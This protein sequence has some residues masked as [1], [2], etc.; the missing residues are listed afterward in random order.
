M[1]IYAPLA[2]SI[3]QLFSPFVEIVIHDLESGKLSFIH[4]A[5]SKRQ[6]G[7]PS[8]LDK[9]IDWDGLSLSEIIYDKI[10]FD[11]RMIKSVSIPLPLHNFTR[12]ELLCINFDTSFFH[13]LKPF[14]DQV[15]ASPLFQEKPEALFKD[16]LDS[17]LHA[18]IH[19]Y[20][21]KHRL[22]LSALTKEQ[23][24]ALLYDLYDKG[25]FEHKNAA[26]VI[27]RILDL[28]RATIYN[29]LKDIK[30]L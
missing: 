7:D 3:A 2:K 29:Y 15:L 20:V 1:S 26:T 19:E 6:V 22:V 16:D 5:F 4:N 11:G 10:N 18:F 13:T 23:K 21:Q 28:S 30:E 12:R 27:G 14:I 17:R 9:N 25:A 8:Y 24:R